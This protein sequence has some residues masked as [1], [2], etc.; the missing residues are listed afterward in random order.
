MKIISACFMISA[1]FASFAAHADI[2]AAGNRAADFAS[3]LNSKT[4]PLPVNGNSISLS[5]KT[6]APNQLVSISYNAVCRV[7]GQV[8]NSWIVA[9]IKVDGVDAL[10]TAGLGLVF[11]ASANATTAIPV[12]ATRTSMMRVPHSGTH[13]V[14][15]SAYGVA[16]SSWSVAASSTIVSQ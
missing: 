4:V 9:L 16:T 12:S 8:G 1:A 5:F 14:T 3:S 6:S 15:V 7:T 2:L 11:C 10:P 13:A